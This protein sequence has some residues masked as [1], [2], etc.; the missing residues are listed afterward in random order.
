MDISADRRWVVSCDRGGDII[1]WDQATAKETRRLHPSEA[2]VT[3]VRF[4]P[5]GKL[6]AT[7]GQDRV[8]RLWNVS[9]W[10]LV[11]QLSKH[12]R[13]INGIA[14]SPD[15]RRIASSDRDG[16]ICIWNVQTQS[17]EQPI[18][19][20]TGPLRCLAWSPDGRVL[21]TADGDLA[22][23]AWET[24]SWAKMTLIDSRVKD[25]L[26]IAFSSDSRYLAF[27]GYGGELSLFDLSSNTLVHRAATPSQIWSLAF[28]VGNELYVGMESGDLQIFRQEPSNANSGLSNSTWQ[29]M[30]TLRIGNNERCIRGILPCSDLEQILVALESD[31]TLHSYSMS[32]VL[33]YRPLKVDTIPVG[34]VPKLNYLLC[35]GEDGNDATLR[36]PHDLSIEFRIPYQI[37][38][39]CL[40]AYLDSQQLLAIACEENGESYANIHRLSDFEL[41]ARLEFSTR[42]RMLSFSRDGKFLAVAGEHGR[43]RI[44]DLVTKTFQDLSH[45]LG[46]YEARAIFSPSSDTLVLGPAG[47][48][49]LFCLHSK[50]LQELRTIET[51][52]GWGY[53]SYHPDCESLI[54]GESDGFAVWKGDLS[55]LL[56]LSPLS[57][58]LDLN[59][60]WSFSFTPDQQTM[61]TLNRNGDVQLWDWRTRSKLVSTPLPVNQP[62]RWLS[63]TDRHTLIVGNSGEPILYTI[64]VADSTSTSSTK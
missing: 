39:Y 27:G 50:T 9:D 21:A 11:G 19:A 15:S 4:S 47:T 26:A 6:L 29:P 48:R 18:P 59:K 63:F 23:H 33:G 13:T 44:W 38:R 51:R 36:R 1:I 53:L 34:I 8:V 3:R 5:D 25:A 22:A 54:V 10:T 37:G 40:P 56:W 2:E 28:G 7:V 49:T 32:S 24:D 41:V 45:G 64:G 14:W 61:A 16:V 55:S 42:I 62:D 20:L 30:R 35:R 43:V 52:T 58:S 17:C 12:Q 60:L 31:R 46:E 57:G